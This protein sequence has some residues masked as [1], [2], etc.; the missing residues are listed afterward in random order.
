MRNS[1]SLYTGLLLVI[2]RCSVPGHPPTYTSPGR[3]GPTRHHRQTKRSWARQ[4]FGLLR[5]WAF[6][7]NDLCRPAGR[8]PCFFFWCVNN[9]SLE[10]FIRN[11]TKPP[12]NSTAKIGITHIADELIIWRHELPSYSFRLHG[13][14]AAVRKASLTQVPSVGD[15]TPLLE[16]GLAVL[17]VVSLLS[18]F[19]RGFRR[20]ALYVAA[21]NSS[22]WRV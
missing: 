5:S 6:P 7:N 22:V 13:F 21:P 17:L 15:H 2:S 3:G 11:K 9:A 10:T 8:S 16:A 4:G 19:R 14:A 18:R 20:S 12:D 1:C